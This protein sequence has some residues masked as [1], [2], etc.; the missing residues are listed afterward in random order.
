MK[1]QDV[2]STVEKCYY[3]SLVGNGGK[4]LHYKKRCPVFLACFNLEP[5][6]VCFD[7]KTPSPTPTVRKKMK[8][9]G[10]ILCRDFLHTLG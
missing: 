7:Q 3:L 9:F 8:F 1:R 6:S 2:P 5:I 4:G 10:E